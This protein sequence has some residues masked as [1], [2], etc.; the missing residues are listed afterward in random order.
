MPCV[1][2]CVCARACVPQVL[3]FES[4]V[5]YSRFTIRV[6]VRPASSREDSEV[7]DDSD[8]SKRRLRGGASLPESRGAARSAVRRALVATRMPAAPRRDSDIGGVAWARR[9]DR[10]TP[11]GP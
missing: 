9:R 5:D 8:V 1:C 2:V 10:P 3:P 6:P 4:A 7:T 11:P